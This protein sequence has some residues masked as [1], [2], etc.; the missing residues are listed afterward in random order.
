MIPL[1]ASE[2]AAIVGGTLCGA[3]VTVTAAPTIDSR[4]ATAGS[5][6]IAFKGDH[7]D[8]HDY[9]GDAQSRGAVVTLAEHPVSEPY[10]LVTDCVTALGK[11]AQEVR[12]RLSQLTVI[13]ITGSQG[14]T[15]TKELLS[16]L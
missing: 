5:L 7:V 15:T 8:G 1:K 13:A 10:I 9:V 14:K 16:S 11:L 2:I 3:D 12:H 4:V 6:F